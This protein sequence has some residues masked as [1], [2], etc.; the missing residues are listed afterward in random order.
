MYSNKKFNILLS[1]GQVVKYSIPTT[2]MKTAISSTYVK[3]EYDISTGFPQSL[4][5]RYTL[6]NHAFLHYTIKT[7]SGHSGIP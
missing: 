4:W 6:T 2:F 5:E 1:S 7:P 3:I